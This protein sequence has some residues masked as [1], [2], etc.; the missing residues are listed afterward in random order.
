MR[1]KVVAWALVGAVALVGAGCGQAK[2]SG[3]TVDAASVEA[4]TAAF[5]SGAASKTADASTG[6]IALTM[7]ISGLG[8]AA[9][10]TITGSGVYDND[11]RQAQL[12]M[13]MSGLTK[14]LPTA[15]A[16][17]GALTEPIEEVVSDGHLYLKLGAV[18]KLLGIT[19]PWV[20]LTGTDAL[21]K[22][23]T[24]SSGMNLDPNDTKSLGTDYLSYLQGVAGTV[25]EVGTEAVDGIDATHYKAE[26]DLAKLMAAAG[27][28]L[29][30]EA[31]SRM[32]SQM[33]KVSGTMPVEVWVGSDGLVRRVTLS[34]DLSA[35]GMAGAKGSMAFTMDFTD[36]GQPVVVTVPPADQV[37]PL[38]L[39]AKM[40]SL[41][42]GLGG[43]SSGTGGN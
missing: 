4:P 6:K 32:Q 22:S 21:A 5:L 27:D 30:P 7:T 34:F 8:S 20:E 41:S 18:G 14:A 39:G 43:L 12:S 1:R 36:L 26:L 2:D 37:S 19:T 25:T 13:D 33:D 15:S 38:D 23:L 11:A 16:S 28:K 9:G 3:G 40:K 10:A 31:K 42:S 24:G 29:S 35:M 17:G